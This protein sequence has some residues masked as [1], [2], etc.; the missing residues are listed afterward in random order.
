MAVYCSP[1]DVGWPTAAHNLVHWC[2][3]VITKE[4]SISDFIGIEVALEPVRGMNVLFSNRCHTNWLL[5]NY[6]H[7]PVPLNWNGM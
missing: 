5:I 2:A 3:P 6:S 7:L 1:Y 4:H